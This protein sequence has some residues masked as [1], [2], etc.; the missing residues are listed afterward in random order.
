V[1]GRVQNEAEYG[2][3]LQAWAGSDPV[4]RR[5]LYLVG[6]CACAECVR[7]SGFQAIYYGTRCLIQHH[8]PYRQSEL[9]AVYKS[10]GGDRPSVS[11]LARQTVTLYVNLPTTFIFIAPLAMLPWGS[12]HALWLILLAG[13]FLLAAFLMWS[14]WS[15]PRA[16]AV[17]LFLVCILLANSEVILVPAIRR[18]LWSASAWWLS[19]VFF[20]SGLCSSESYVWRPAS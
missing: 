13:A 12:A 17:S 18:G 7:V 2:G 8:N 4:E 16:P 9:E 3:S 11:A 14:N 19:G 5:N 15:E 10:E 6:Y 1:V 20:R